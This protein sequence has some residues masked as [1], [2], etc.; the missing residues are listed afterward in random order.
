M[1]SN[2]STKNTRNKSIG[3]WFKNAGLHN[4]IEFLNTSK[5][6]GFGKRDQS[7]FHAYMFWKLPTIISF[8][9]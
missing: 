1:D 6:A 8:G 7:A 3:V 5:I 2:L 4:F 9:D